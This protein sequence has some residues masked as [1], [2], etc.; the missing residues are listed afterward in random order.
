M[1]LDFGGG[2]L[3]GSRKSF[4]QYELETEDLII[5]T[6]AFA[7]VN[8]ETVYTVT[9]GKTLF[10]S[11]VSLINKDGNAH[12]FVLKINTTTVIEHEVAASTTQFFT[13][14]SPVP[15]ASTLVVAGE[16]NHINSAISLI[17]W[18]K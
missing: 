6:H 1:A 15:I 8:E 14:A 12:T 17:G 7:S 11:Q 3:F 2:G 5:T 18:E 10:I 16:S 4:K 13:F 9:T